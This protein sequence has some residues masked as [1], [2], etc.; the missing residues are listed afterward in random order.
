MVRVDAA[1]RVGLRQRVLHMQFVRV[2]GVHALCGLEEHV[3][4]LLVFGD[5]D[6]TAQ[7][8]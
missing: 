4:A 2:H 6:S 1:E 8:L 7:P 5:L 3:H